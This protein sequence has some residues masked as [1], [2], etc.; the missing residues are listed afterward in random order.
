MSDYLNTTLDWLELNG[1]SKKIEKWFFFITWK[2]I[3]D[4]GSDRYMGI[5]FFDGPNPGDPLNCLGELYRA[6]SLALPDLACDANGNTVAR[7]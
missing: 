6:R 5:I 1:P 4:V 7:Q 3:V 2:D